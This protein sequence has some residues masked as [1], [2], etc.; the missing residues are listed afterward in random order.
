MK[1]KGSK[2]GKG[3]K[4]STPGS[5]FLPPE[6][7]SQDIANMDTY[8]Q[9]KRELAKRKRVRSATGPGKVKN[10][11]VVED[12]INGITGEVIGTTSLQQFLIYDRDQYAYRIRRST[13]EISIVS[14]ID[15]LVLNDREQKVYRHHLHVEAAGVQYKGYRSGIAHRQPR[16]THCWK[17]QRD[18]SSLDDIE[19]EVC[20]W[21]ICECGACG[22]G[23]AGPIKGRS[24]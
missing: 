22:C 21:L 18:L 2:K 19:C 9:Q 3:K 24:S 12:K 14:P 5:T 10:G 11:T 16:L 6:R 13:G 23:Y 17:C 1:R 7:R 15:I 8:L 20:G 4:K